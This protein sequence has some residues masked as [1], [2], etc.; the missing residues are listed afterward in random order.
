MGTIAAGLAGAAVAE[1]IIIPAIKDLTPIV[2]GAITS[3]IEAG[4]NKKKIGAAMI[5]MVKAK[6]QVL[7]AMAKSMEDW[8]GEMPP[9]VWQMF[10]AQQQEIL[11]FTDKIGD[12][13]RGYDDDAPEAKK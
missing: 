12:F 6:Q 2:A 5:T 11:M 7:I 8:Q 3:I 1:E 13:L 10:Q 9:I 4:G